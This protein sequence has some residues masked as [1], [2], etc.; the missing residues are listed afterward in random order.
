MD[1]DPSVLTIQKSMDFR[2]GQL[3][4]LLKKLLG[5]SAYEVNKLSSRMHRHTAA[6][7]VVPKQATLEQEVRKEVIKAGMVDD[8]SGLVILSIGEEQDASR[9]YQT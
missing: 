8:K 4:C 5:A 9:K 2:D 3:T 1:P 7:P 6:K